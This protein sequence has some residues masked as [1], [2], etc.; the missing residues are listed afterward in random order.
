MTFY[1]SVFIR[2]G[3]DGLFLVISVLTWLGRYMTLLSKQK[4]DKLLT[5]KK[6]KKKDGRLNV[7]LTLQVWHYESL[8]LFHSL[9]RKEER[10][11][12][13]QIERLQPLPWQVQ[14][15]CLRGTE[16]EFFCNI[17]LQFTKNAVKNND[18]NC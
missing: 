11:Q 8:S 6:W 16:T 1:Y 2:T 10:S 7:M 13:P 9:T 14:S 5:K 12:V 18:H 15:G 3:V 17:V 4:C